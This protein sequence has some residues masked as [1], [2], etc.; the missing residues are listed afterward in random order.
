MKLLAIDTSGPAM[1]CAVVAEGRVV[2]LVAMHRALT[3]SETNN[4]NTADQTRRKNH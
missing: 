4:N 1:S 3:H 2:C